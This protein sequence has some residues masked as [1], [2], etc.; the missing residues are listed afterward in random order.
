MTKSLRALLAT[1]LLATA[2]L[3]GVQ[4]AAAPPASAVPTGCEFID[5]PIPNMEGKVSYCAGG[6]GF[7]RI[8]LVCREYVGGPTH[9]VYGEWAAP[10]EY[11][12]TGCFNGDLGNF[13]NSYHR[14]IINPG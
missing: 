14:E 1:G 13:M 7:H 3:G 5:H 9:W 12:T 2:A 4:V 10:G 6:V 8:A 11:S